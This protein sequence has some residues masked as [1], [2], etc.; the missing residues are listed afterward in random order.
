MCKNRNSALIKSLLCAGLI[1]AGGMTYIYIPSHTCAVAQQSYYI[2][3]FND[4]ERDIQDIEKIFMDDFYWL[5]TRDSYDVRA[6]LTRRTSDFAD[7]T[8][9]NDMFIYVMRD[10][11]TDG[12]IGFV[13]FFKLSFYKGQVLFL[14][15]NREFRGK[16]YGRA[17]VSYALDQMKNMGMIKAK[18]FTRLDN[19]PARA[20]YESLGF[21]ETSR[22]SNV[23]L[24]YDLY[25]Q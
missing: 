25:L 11:A 9:N 17:L 21:Q 8:V 6:M 10:K 24:Y 13:T 2:Y 1:I 14:S 23:G 3:P 15:V 19:K 22:V 4:D 5:T 20:L 18:L 16:G 7:P 12:L